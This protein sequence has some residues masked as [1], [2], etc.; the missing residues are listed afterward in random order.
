LLNVNIIIKR[1]ILL[2]RIFT[3]T[4]KSGI[5]KTIQLPKGVYKQ[6]FQDNGFSEQKAQ[7]PCSAPTSAGGPTGEV[8][9]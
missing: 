1:I 5:V 7:A 8:V 3:R 2:T 9:L 6:F 4:I